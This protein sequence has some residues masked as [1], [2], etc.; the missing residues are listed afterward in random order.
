MAELPNPSDDDRPPGS[1]PELPRVTVDLPPANSNGPVRTLKEDDDLQSAIDAATPGDVIALPPGAVFKGAV[2]LRKKAGDAW[3]TI[4]TSTP[5]DVFPAAG[6][7]VSPSDARLMPVI[8]ADADNAIRA[9]P[10]AHHYRFIGIE[11]RPPSGRFLYN[12]ILFGDGATTVDSLPHHIVFERCYLH[13]DP[14]AGTRRGIALN[15]RHT[16]II[17][18]YLSD[19]KE[20]GSDSQAIAGWNGT[21]PFAI[22][23]NYL[24]GAGE[25]I[26][27]GGADPTIKNLVPSD[28]VVTG[29]SIAKPLSWKDANAYTENSLWSVKNLFELKNARRVLID[30]N[31]FEYNWPNGQNGYAILFTP[32][33]QDG[34]SPWSM[35]RDVTFRNNLVRHVPS[36]FNIL[37]ADDINSSQPTKRILIKDNVFADI[38]DVN[39]GGP[40]NLIQ[41]LNA[42]A[43]ITV[44]HNTAFDTHAVLVASGDPNPRFTFT[45][46]LTQAGEYG[47]G[48][49]SYYGNPR[50]ALTTYFPAAIFVANVLQGASE[51]DYPAGNYFPPSVDDVGFIDYKNGDYRLQSSSPFKNAGTDGKD[52]G[53]SND[54]LSTAPRRHAVRPQ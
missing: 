13:G 32:R 19:F 12:L 50:G 28:I 11:I 21:G 2:T 33:N 15:S 45:N 25:N 31:V 26:M 18:S 42:A 22:E 10:G 17:D 47:V 52:I 24:E 20:K 1:P 9:E 35:V 54:S 34:H 37:G 41:V 40:G 39:W 48:G 30:H 51:G 44:D 46:N 5:D 49:D 38:N 23:N 16:A 8:E 7:R 14:V 4:R 3:V 43:D 29:N 36:G 27:F 6:T 53:A